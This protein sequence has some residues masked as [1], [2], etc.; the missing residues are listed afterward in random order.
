MLFKANDLT[1][2]FFGVLKIL[3]LV[4]KQTFA[5]KIVY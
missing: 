1:I 5:E 2:E 4:S 3:P